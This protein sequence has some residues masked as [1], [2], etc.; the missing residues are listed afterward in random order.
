MS[1]V[2]REIHLRQCCC[3]V[4]AYFSRNCRVHRTGSLEDE[5]TARLAKAS[6]AFGRLRKRLWNDH[7]IRI[8]TKL[9]VYHAVVLT[10]LLYGSESWTLYK[11]H[12]QKL[13]SFHLRCLRQILHIKWQDKLPNTS[14]LEKCNI[15]GI[16]ALLV[17]T[18][19]RGC[20][21]VSRMSDDRIPKRLLYGQ[22]SGA[23]RRPGGQRKRY[24]DQLRVNLQTC[25]IDPKRWE[26]LAADRS[27][28]RALFHN[29][30]DNF[31]EQRTEAIKT[32]RIARK[33]GAS[34]NLTSTSYTCDICGRVCRSRIGLFSHRKSH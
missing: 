29:A 13:D 22:L 16:K 15:T 26:A 9:Q 18:Q 8:D 14:V 33:S 12:I 5:I 19:F 30:V 17:R 2:S 24:K 32:K 31:E 25:D 1:Y 10:T 11:R 28:W 27:S 3:T 6:S 20:G 4:C 34:A 7:G 23:K 21:H